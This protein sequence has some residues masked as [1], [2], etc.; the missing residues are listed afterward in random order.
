MAKDL[1][2]PEWY[3]MYQKRFTSATQLY[4]AEAVGAYIVLLN[5]QWDNGGLPDDI[6]QLVA[7]ARCSEQTIHR[8]LKKFQKLDDGLYWNKRL[9][10]IR[11]EQHAKYLVSKARADKTNE[12]KRIKRLS[13]DVT[14]NE[15]PTSDQ[16]HVND[17]YKE[18]EE[19]IS[20]DIIK[21][22]SEELT[23][24]KKREV[25]VF[26]KPEWRD[27][28]NYWLKYLPTKGW[29]WDRNKIQDEAENFI[30]HYKSNNWMVGKN[31]MQ[32]WEASA[33]NWAKNNNKFEVGKD[34]TLPTVVLKPTVFLGED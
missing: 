10:D 1:F 15:R 4:N 16:R 30:D 23:N 2:T 17:T 5:Y 18:E 11:E 31:K 33:R 34:G 29:V 12:I 8:V 25:K 24:K 14:S 21:G 9:E 32:D 13:L 22:V 19:D 20:K 26:I 7:L 27:V 6:E 3:P 28:A